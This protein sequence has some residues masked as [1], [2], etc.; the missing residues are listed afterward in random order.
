MDSS[1]KFCLE[2][3]EIENGQL[4]DSLRDL[5]VENQRLVEQI[6]A[7]EKSLEKEKKFHRKYADDVAAIESIRIEDYKKEKRALIEENKSLVRENRQLVKDVSFYK[8]A[9]EE[10][11]KE[12]EATM[13][14]SKI[15]K[16]LTSCESNST[17]QS[18]YGLR[19]TST[20]ESQTISYSSP[21]NE[22][23]H[24]SS[25]IL[26]VA[27]N[28]LFEE[29]K[30]LKLKISNLNA[31]ITILKK[32]NKQL[33]SFQD[34]VNKKKCKFHE[35]VDELERLVASTQKKNKDTFTPKALAFIGHLAKNKK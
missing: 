18:V 9:H 23:T 8:K 3:I 12:G 2:G 11:A 32:K 5:E 34:K 7:L 30:K 10:L 6:N 31:T 14:N 16:S 1:I 33:E 26:S 13:T 22:C 4:N 28:K 19:R 24:K 29:N 25:K 27:S 21:L 15:P 35:D 17:R 20:S